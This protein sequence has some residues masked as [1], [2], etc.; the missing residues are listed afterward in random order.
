MTIEILPTKFGDD[1]RILYRLV[2]KNEYILKVYNIYHI[3]EQEEKSSRIKGKR[4]IRNVQEIEVYNDLKDKDVVE[5][6]YGNRNINSHYLF[7]KIENQS[8]FVDFKPWATK[9]KLKGPFTAIV[10]KRHKGFVSLKFAIPKMTWKE[11]RFFFIKIM[12]KHNHLNR[13]FNFVHGDLL[14]QNVLIRRKTNEIKLFDFDVSTIGNKVSMG[15]TAYI[16]FKKIY[17]LTGHK[18]FLFDF[19]RLYLNILCHTYNKCIFNNKYKF[20]NDLVDL[21]RHYT[22]HKYDPHNDTSL[23]CDWIQRSGTSSKTGTNKDYSDNQRNKDIDL[24]YYNVKKFIYQF[25][26]E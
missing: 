20:L 1:H 21:Y 7:I 5:Y 18:G 4:N 2:G 9:F 25:Q 14:T 19:C 24:L 12:R 3:T 22:K 10:T 11:I 16:N 6:I 8:I 13:I 15:Q 17:P 23:F 26:I